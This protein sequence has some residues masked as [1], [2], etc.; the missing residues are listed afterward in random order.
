MHVCTH[1]MCSHASS[2]S[3]QA[4]TARGSSWLRAPRTREVRRMARADPTR[5]AARVTSA[6]SILSV[7]A[8]VI[9]PR[10][11]HCPPRPVAPPSP[12]NRFGS[13]VSAS[14]R[15]HAHTCHSAHRDCGKPCAYETASFGG[16]GARKARRQASAVCAVGGCTHSY[17]W[18]R[19]SCRLQWPGR[20]GSATAR[21]D[22]GRSV[23]FRVRGA[24]CLSHKGRA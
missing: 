19:S 9:G 6:T 11:P 10:R 5:H 3:M 8:P 23:A 1:P 15:A 17:A 2:P 4:R 22:S 20:S 14:G 13:L 16:H 7:S 12:L 24:A 21:A 18:A